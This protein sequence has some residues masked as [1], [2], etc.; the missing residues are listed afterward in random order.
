MNPFFCCKLP[1]HQNCWDSEVRKVEK[2]SSGPLK[3]RISLQK[4]EILQK[5]PYKLPAAL[6][7]KLIMNLVEDPTSN[8][9]PYSDHHGLVQGKF[10]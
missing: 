4:Q 6:W 3:P 8:P 9:C 7:L 1:L 2:P 5:K 10:L